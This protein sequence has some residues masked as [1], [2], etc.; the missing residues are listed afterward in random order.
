MGEVEVLSMYQQRG[1]IWFL[2]GD[3]CKLQHSK[4]LIVNE[5]ILFLLKGLKAPWASGC[6]FS[7]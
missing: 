1:D 3:N 2:A 6:G 7:I 4:K 5:G